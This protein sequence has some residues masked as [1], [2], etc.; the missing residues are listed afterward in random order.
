MARACR[1][2]EMDPG[3][4]DSLQYKYH[5][6]IICYCLFHKCSNSSSIWNWASTRL[7]NNHP[8]QV[9]FWGDQMMQKQQTKKMKRWLTMMKTTIQ[10]KM[11]KTC[12]FE[13]KPTFLASYASWNEKNNQRAGLRCK[14]GRPHRVRHL[15]WSSSWT[16]VAL[17]SVFS[18]ISFQSCAFSPK[19]DPW[20]TAKWLWRISRL[21]K[22]STMFWS[23]ISWTIKLQSKKILPHLLEIS[24]SRSSRKPINKLSSRRTLQPKI[25]KY[26]SKWTSQRTKPSSWCLS[27]CR[28]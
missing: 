8:A 21:S 24:W 1:M 9:I 6:P 19:T 13:G 16:I 7:R 23:N 10:M 5:L 15:C 27:I 28:I 11:R 3:K 4:Q 25:I 22:P 18:L 26:S 2:W 20:S 14:A 17:T 12:I